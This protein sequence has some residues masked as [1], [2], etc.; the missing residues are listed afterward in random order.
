MSIIDE[1]PVQAL[2][3]ALAASQRPDSAVQVQDGR[4]EAVMFIHSFRKSAR[5]GSLAA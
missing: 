3:G 2:I 1:H 4:G 5:V